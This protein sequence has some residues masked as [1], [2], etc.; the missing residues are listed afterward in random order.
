L[1]ASYLGLAS[2]CNPPDLIFASWVARITNMSHWYPDFFFFHISCVSE[3]R[4]VS[5]RPSCWLEVLITCSLSVDVFSMF[6]QERVVAGW[7]SIFYH[8]AEVID[9]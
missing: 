5:L 4:F 1:W 6:R 7:G 9:H 8:W 3:L 2:N